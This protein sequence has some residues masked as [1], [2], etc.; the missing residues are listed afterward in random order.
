MEMELG[1]RYRTL[2]TLWL[3]MM[4]NVGVFFVFTEFSAPEISSDPENA[5]NTVLIGALAAVGAL[6]VLASFVVK[7]KM[8]NRSVEKQDVN[9][10]HTALVIAW[11]MC[12]PIVLVGV[13]ARLS[14]GFRQYYLLLPVAAIAMAFHYPR[15]DQLLA[16]T[17]K[18]L[19]NEKRS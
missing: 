15:R 1:Q 13:V 6:F 8:L 3:A 10:V 19:R 18:N 12:E 9:L 11:A 4:M 7:R 2:R 16:A 17:Y 14:L 5:P